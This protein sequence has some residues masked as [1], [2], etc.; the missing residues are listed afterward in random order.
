MDDAGPDLS[1]PDGHS[2]FSVSSW[3]VNSIKVRLPLLT[4]YLREFAP[5][6]MMLQEIKTENA[7]FPFFELKSAG[8]HA[9]VNGQKGYAGVAILSK[10]PLKHVA[11]V[12]AGVPDEDSPQARFIEAESEN[13][14][15]FISVYVP[16]GQP[17]ASAPD[18]LERLEY[19][20]AWLDALVERV[21]FLMRREIPFVL[22]GDFN[23]IETD[24]D[25]YDP[26]PFENG[27]F[28]LPCVRERFRR[29]AF[30][31]LTEALRAKASL[32]P[33][34]SYWDYQGGARKKNNGILLDRL[35]LSP[36]FADALKSATVDDIYRDKE[37]TSDHAPVRCVFTPEIV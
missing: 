14:R 23:V 34:Y 28:T 3:N 5:D 4:E 24:E 15:H 32:R 31:G 6:V 2:G 12:P 13:G 35:F 22:G 27:A 30:A 37:K 7:L 17:P 16:N 11:D 20:T 33:L 29:L 9:L 18:S 21:S 8:Y 19:K 36:D 10:A 26:R 25:V 1:T